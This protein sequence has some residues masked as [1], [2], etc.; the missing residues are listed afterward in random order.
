MELFSS[1]PAQVLDFVLQ[2]LKEDKFESITCLPGGPGYRKGDGRGQR[3]EILGDRIAANPL[4]H[5]AHAFEEILN[6]QNAPGALVLK[7]VQDPVPDVIDK[8]KIGP[9]A[10]LGSPLERDVN[11]SCFVANHL[12]AADLKNGKLSDE[13]DHGRTIP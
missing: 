10:G 8:G 12:V 6:W 2:L 9:V 13:A 4:Q 3:S 1:A 7:V 5:A 11:P